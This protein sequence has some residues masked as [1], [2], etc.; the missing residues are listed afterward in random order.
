[1]LEDVAQND[2]VKGPQSREIKG[3]KF[4]ANDLR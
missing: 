1:M 2:T 4:G 3:V